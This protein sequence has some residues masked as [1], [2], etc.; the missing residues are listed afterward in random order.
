MVI[1]EICDHLGTFGSNL[2]HSMAEQLILILHDEDFEL[3][4][5]KDM[6]R[7]FEYCENIL[8]RETENLVEKD[9]SMKDE[10]NV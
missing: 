6:V 9:G 4:R 1:C 2:G 7:L 5:F 10:I 3:S 8:S